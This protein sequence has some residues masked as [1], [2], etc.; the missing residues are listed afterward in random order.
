VLVPQATLLGQ[1]DVPLDRPITTIGSNESARLHLVSRTVSKGHAIFVNSNGG[2]YVADMASKTGV[3]VNGK[4]VREADLKTGDRVQIGKFVFRYRT[5]PNTGTAPDATRVPPAAVILVGSPAM[6]VNTRTVFIGRRENDDIHL[7]SDAGVSEAHAVIFECDGRWNIRDLGSRT[8][9]VVN[10]NP[11]ARPQR[12]NFGDRIVVGSNT[13]LFQP[14]ASRAIEEQPIESDTLRL[15]DSGIAEALTPAAEATQVA[16]TPGPAPQVPLTPISR[17]LPVVRTAGMTDD[18]VPLADEIS[19]K[20]IEVPV[21]QDPETILAEPEAPLIS[22]PVPQEQEPHDVPESALLEN[23]QTEVTEHPVSEALPAEA[24]VTAKTP[25]QPA[26]SA[27]ESASHHAVIDLAA[28]EDV[29]AQP[30]DAGVAPAPEKSTAEPPIEISAN[31]AEPVHAPE[32]ALADAAAPAAAAGVAPASPVP[33]EQLLAEVEDFVFVPEK[34]DAVPAVLFWGDGQTENAAR[35]QELDAGPA[36]PHPPVE[37]PQTAAALEVGEPPVAQ[38]DGLHATADMADAPAAMANEPDQTPVDQPLPATESSEVSHAEPSALE[39][40]HES[41]PTTPPTDGAAERDA[42][43]VESVELPADSHVE[44]PGQRDQSEASSPAA[45]LSGDASVDALNDPFELEF[46]TDETTDIAGPYD[47]ASDGGEALTGEAAATEPIVELD[48]PAVIEPIPVDAESADSP[49]SAPFAEGTPLETPTLGS[50]ESHEAVEL[51]DQPDDL[52]SPSGDLGTEP[53]EVGAPAETASDSTVEPHAAEPAIV[54]DS[55]ETG[56]AAEGVED[57]AGNAPDLD[58]PD[59]DDLE[60]ALPEESHPTALASEDDISWADEPAAASPTDSLELGGEAL[61]AGESVTI[62]SPAAD[63]SAVSNVAIETPLDES[64][65]HSAAEVSDEAFVVDERAADDHPSQAPAVADERSGESNEFELEFLDFGEPG[66]PASDA[67]AESVTPVEEPATEAADTAPAAE[68]LT[69]DLPE[70]EAGP[71]EAGTT[72]AAPGAAGSAAPDAAPGEQSRRPS[73]FGFKFEGGSFLGG[74]PLS[75]AGTPA[76]VVPPTVASIPAFDAKANRPHGLGGTLPPSPEKSPTPIA[77]AAGPAVAPIAPAPASPTEAP[78]AAAETKA[79]TDETPVPRRPTTPPPIK[80][81]P[82]PM[83]SLT[84]LVSDVRKPWS[85]APMIPPVQKTPG[86]GGRTP[87][88]V[89]A[90]P[91]SSQQPPRGLTGAPGGRGTAARTTEVFSQLSAPI[92]VEVF[93]G[94][95]GNPNQFVVPDTTKS[96]GDATEGAGGTKDTSGEAPAGPRPGVLPARRKRWSPLPVLVPLLVVIPAVI[97]AMVYAFVPVSSMLVGRLAFDGLASQ[98]PVDAHDFVKHEEGLLYSDSL[99]QRA[100]TI[101]ARQGLPPGFTADHDQFSQIVESQALNWN[102]N[103][104]EFTLNTSDRRR[105]NAL[106]LAVLNALTELDHDLDD[107]RQKARADVEDARKGENDLNARIARL[108]ADHRA[109]AEKAQDSPDPALVADTDHQV[110]QLAKQWK[111]AVN[112]RQ[113]REAEL[114]ELSNVDP[115]KPID[116]ETDSKVVNWKAELQR[117][118]DQIARVKDS[119]GTAGAPPDPTADPL[120]GALQKQADDLGKKLDSRRAELAAEAAI[121]PE[122]RVVNQQA[123]KETLSIK[124]T[125]LKQAEAD[126]KTQLDQATAKAA[127]IHARQD[128]ARAAGAKAED[129]V[130]SITEANNMLQEQVHLLET[131]ETAYANCITVAGPPTVSVASVTD[132][133]KPIALGLTA[134]SVVVLGLL[135]AGELRRRPKLAITP[136]TPAPAPLVNPSRVIPWPQPQ[137][138]AG[139]DKDAP[140]AD[141]ES[142]EVFGV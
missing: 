87:G 72:G 97:W 113:T 128:A 127:A 16:E 141:T 61:E 50:V 135:I 93:G 34:A 133:R 101:L 131:K 18:L 85:G 67:S 139:L 136:V 1:P 5:P 14:A 103:T 105:G 108:D 28:R 107:A 129:L 81:P 114:S 59:M 69:F 52:L 121:P 32:N 68:E 96:P 30:A 79:V 86:Q 110:E 142:E 82:T 77:R 24:Y 70:S 137:E 62:T 37:P 60:F 130:A 8:G 10:G 84:G 115:S 51:G 117:L 91:K 3:L 48:D 98:Q 25:G 65:T 44:S 80:R 31:R 56:A 83:P 26:A 124:I 53:L 39:P 109:L 4:L 20:P 19:P 58:R 49:S 12:L 46:A 126:L 118:N 17:D 134:L 38:S 29:P 78:V 71:T 35:R 100:Q 7:P 43:S 54:A 36:E 125:G 140:P 138:I 73:L 76:P 132:M 104:L 74:M 89:P 88:Q 2:T 13:I 15:S 94:R 111:D 95:P 122:Q 47:G 11:I 33:V 66:Q 57:L 112:L 106:V 45:G 102:G 75:L 27:D 6:I 90:R 92:G 42:L 120:L 23:D 40:A 64:V 123:A 63:L 116:P 99:R 21:Q 119:A 9:T 41:V 55:I 22:E